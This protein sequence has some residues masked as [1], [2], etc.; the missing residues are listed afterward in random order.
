VINK[1]VADITYATVQ[2]RMFISTMTESVSGAFEAKFACKCDEKN[3]I[4]MQLEEVMQ[5]YQE[6]I[7]Y[8]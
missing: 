3:I 4:T 7:T 2:L 6:C 1:Y 5:K 8:F